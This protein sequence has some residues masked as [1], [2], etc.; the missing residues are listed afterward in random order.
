[1]KEELDIDILLKN[2]IT[3]KEDIIE[4]LVSILKSTND[5]CLGNKIAFALVDNFRD[6]RIETCLVDLIQDTRWKNSNGTLLYLLGEYTNDQK[7]LLFLIDMILKN[8][9]NDDGEVFMAAYGMIINMQPP[10][11]RKKIT[12]AL[13]L[14]RREERKKKITKEQ[15]LLIRSLLKYLEGQKEIIKFYK[16]FRQ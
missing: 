5:F 2:I 1:M 16:Q 7:Y 12:R 11:D 14:V 3:Q 8:E 6:D 13:Q 15:K 4:K 9:K 10:L